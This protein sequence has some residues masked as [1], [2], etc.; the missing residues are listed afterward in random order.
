MILSLQPYPTYKHSGVEWLGE[1]PAHWEAR[2]LGSLG[3]F[4]ASG[5]DKKTNECEPL[6]RMVNYLDVFRNATHTLDNDRDYMVVSCPEWK[7]RVHDVRTG[8]MVFTPSSET[9]EEI[10]YSAVAVEDI[11]NGVYSYHVLRFRPSKPLDLFFQRYWCNASGVLNQFSVASKGTTRQILNRSDFRSTCVPVP[12]LGEQQAIGRY[13]AYV[14]RRVRRF[15]RA[16]Q[17]LI[18]LLT[19]QKQVI[20]H[21]AVTRG[22]DPEAPLKDSGVEWLGEVP[23]HWEVRQMGRIGRFS[24]G[25]GGTKEDEVQCGV[26]CIRYGDLYTQHRFFVQKARS[27][28]SQDASKSYTPIHYGDVLF[29]GSGETIEEIGKSAVNLITETACC[30]GDVVIFRSAIGVNAKFLGLATDCPYAAYQKSCMGRGITI[31]H[32]YGTEL[33]YM[34]VAF[35]PLPEQTAIVE[36]LDKATADIDTTLTRTGREIELVN[37]YRTR[38]MADLVTGKLE[39]REAAAQLPDEPDEPHLLDED[40]APTNSE[41]GAGKKW[42]R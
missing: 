24:K 30:G 4:S 11:E 22:L 29:A 15:V 34:S 37:E 36:Y 31:M 27:F 19:E 41:E 33:K 6:I 16:K 23:A 32:I 10:G 17:K 39:V 12:P 38:L 3:M 5:I 20:I 8:D 35:P 26:P 7:R 9:T 40:D 25:S 1:V 28:V 2:R 14:E 21:R 42:E 13:L 18:A